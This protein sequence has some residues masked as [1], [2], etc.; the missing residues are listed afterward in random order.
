MKHEFD[1]RLIRSFLA[2]L[3]NGSLLGA[4]RVLGTTQPTVGRHIAELESQLGVVLFERTGRG[5]LATDMA[6][7]LE[8]SARAMEG[9][10]MQIAR[11]VSGAQEAITGSVRI[12][13]SQTIACFVMPGVLAQMR[14]ALPEVQ[15]D[16]V[17]SNAVSNLLRREADIALRM[18][19]PDQA[20]LVT[21][22]IAKVTL[23][24]YAHRDYLRRRGIPRQITDLASHEL[25]GNDRD[26]AIL[27]GFAQFGV[28]VTREA[29]AFR[30]DDL[31]A[32]WEA[33]RAG[34]GIGFVADY[35]A[36]MDSDL[37]PVLPMLKVPPLPIWLTVHREI[38]TSPRIR[39]VYDF[40]AGA[41][42][43]AL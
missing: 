40:L 15:V 36:R 43:R 13:A 42:P 25:V 6:H 26:E 19:Q 29:F 31:V 12:S 9:S 39:A 3:D 22:R 5:L 18:V 32:Y 34:L 7:W 8:T 33:V 2:A 11:S 17:S 1:W 23:G 27:K 14:S 38:R 21:R 28:P 16:L 24:A 41:V 30:T 37:V 35:L 20:S 4:A 10:A